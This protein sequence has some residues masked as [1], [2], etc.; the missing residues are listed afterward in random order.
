MITLKNS[1]NILAVSTTKQVFAFVDFNMV[2]PTTAATYYL[3][4][5]KH[6]YVGNKCI[7]ALGVLVMLEENVSAGV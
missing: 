3:H 5:Y 2:F 6:V 1:L 7:N 4:A